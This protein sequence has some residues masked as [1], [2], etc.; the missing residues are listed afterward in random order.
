MI[1][2]IIFDLGGVLVLEAGN[3]IQKGMADFLNLPIQNLDEVTL[4]F[5][6]QLTIGKISLHE[7]YSMLIENEHLASSADKALAN[8]LELYRQLSTK[9]DERIISLVNLLK[10]K[11]TVVALTNTELEIAGFNKPNG[12][13]SYFSKAYISTDL[14]LRKPQPEIYLKVIS[15]LGLD[16][17]PEK[18]IFI[19]DNPEYINGAKKIGINA[20]QYTGFEQLML[21]LNNYKLIDKNIPKWK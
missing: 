18:A 20:I 16:K 4:P 11:Y 3:K 10:E 15:D 6:P 12:L 14:G 8:H 9:R 17:A 21:E 2:A 1:E 13:F 5:R 7:M 19:G